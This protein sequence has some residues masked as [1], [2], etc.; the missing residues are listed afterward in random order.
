M[1]QSNQTNQL[2]TLSKVCEQLSDVIS[3]APIEQMEQQLCRQEQQT[4][5]NIAWLD[6][7]MALLSSVSEV[8]NRQQADRAISRIE[9]FVSKNNQVKNT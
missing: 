3:T 7:A 5:Q 9:Q 6:E 8:E 4:A 2:D 1:A